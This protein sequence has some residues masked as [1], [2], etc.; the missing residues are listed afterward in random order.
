MK[1][2]TPFLIA[3]CSVIFACNDAGKTDP[4]DT[5]DSANEAKQ[6][7]A[8]DSGNTAGGNTASASATPVDSESADFFVKAA[9]GGMAEVAAGKLA[10][11]KATNPKVKEFASMMVTDH[12]GANSGLKELASKKNVTLPDTVSTDHQKSAADLG[13]KT[14]KD[15][16]KAYMDMQVKDH[17][18]TVD[19]FKDGSKNVKDTELKAFIDQTLPK[20]QAHLDAA[21]ALKKTVSQ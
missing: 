6:D 19:L 5:A 7:Q 12:T 14:G 16:D 13:K 20:L 10:Q 4:V 17:E 11:E 3:L 15:F 21:K 2:A 9:D 1:K 8:Q 18:K